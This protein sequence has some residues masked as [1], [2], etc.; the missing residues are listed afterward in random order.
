[1]YPYKKIKLTD[2]TTKDEHRLVMEKHLGRRLKSW[3]CVHHKNGDKRDNR[4]ENLELSTRKEHPLI[5]KEFSIALWAKKNLRKGTLE[6]GWCYVC[7]QH[8]SKEEM[9]KKKS[10]WNGLHN[11]CKE[12]QRIKNRERHKKK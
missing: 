7:K 12:C 3:E 10:K 1:M 9:I 5:H 8:K 11:L 2:G 6:T 4:I